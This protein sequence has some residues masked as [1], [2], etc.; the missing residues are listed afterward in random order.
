MYRILSSY[1]RSVNVIINI[2]IYKDYKQ[3]STKLIKYQIHVSS[4]LKSTNLIPLYKT[5]IK[6]L[7]FIN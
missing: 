7:W 2:D 4:Y 1:F 6:Y 5:K 3:M